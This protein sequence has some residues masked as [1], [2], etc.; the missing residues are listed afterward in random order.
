MHDLSELQKEGNLGALIAGSPVWKIRNL[1]PEQ[2]DN[3][4]AQIFV[5][6]ET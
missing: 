2:K 6:S 3:A 5:S 4:P 1:N